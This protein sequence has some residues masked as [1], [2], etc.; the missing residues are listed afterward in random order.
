MKP[1][2]TA[3]PSKLL[4]F[5]YA[6]IPASRAGAIEP[7]DNGCF[8]LPVQQAFIRNRRIMPSTT[9]M[10]MLLNGWAGKGGPIHTTQGAIARK[11]GYSV[12]QVQRMFADA[13]REGYLKYA[14][15]KCRMGWIIGVTIYLRQARVL[16]KKTAVT[17]KNWDTTQESDI[18]GNFYLDNKIDDDLSD[19]LRRL[20]QSMG[21][22]YDEIINPDG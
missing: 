17:R 14:K 22:D 1:L 10:L 5:N 19:R 7:V 21:I 6:D 9:K 4:Y 3:M 18:N 8:V 15:R 2:F 11:L 16:K 12:R 20:G 13:E